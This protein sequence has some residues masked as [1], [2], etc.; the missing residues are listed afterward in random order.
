MLQKNKGFFLL[1]LLLSISA[2]LMMCLFF[3]PILLDLT[4]QSRKEEV[5]K[6][7]LQLLYEE[8]E[9]KL[10]TDQAY[11]NY[12]FFSNSIEYKIRWK[13]SQVSNQKE[14]CVA[15]ENNTF[16]SEMEICRLQE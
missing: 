4:N 10:G 14:V 1:E 2:W 3:I 12:S 7:A 13:D 6:K 15:V 5:E 9:A 11:T 8:L 16:L